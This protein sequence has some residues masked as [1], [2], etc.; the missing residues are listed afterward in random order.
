MKKTYLHFFVKNHF[1]SLQFIRKVVVQ[2]ILYIYFSFITRISMIESYHQI[3]F[4][5]YHKFQSIGLC[6]HFYH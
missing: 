5:G 2:S 3:P 1:I 4:L 6:V